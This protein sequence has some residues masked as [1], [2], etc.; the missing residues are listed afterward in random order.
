MRV[1]VS[2]RVHAERGSASSRGMNPRGLRRPS[3][4]YKKVGP[5]ELIITDVV[6]GE[7][8]VHGIAR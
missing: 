8:D 2:D 6:R 1:V 4:F 7:T 5:G 3:L